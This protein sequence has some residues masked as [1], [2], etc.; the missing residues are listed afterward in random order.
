MIDV[1]V[2]VL[3]LKRIAPLVDWIDEMKPNKS[4]FLPLNPATSDSIW[5]TTAERGRN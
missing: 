4:R 1:Q 2:T 3:N 5:F